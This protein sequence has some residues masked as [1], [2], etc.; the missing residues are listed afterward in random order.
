VKVVNALP[1]IPPSQ[2]EKDG[3]TPSC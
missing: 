3:S 1:D 2:V